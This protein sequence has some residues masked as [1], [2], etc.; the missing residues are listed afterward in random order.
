MTVAIRLMRFGKK[1]Q[2]QY[3]IVALDKRKK[4]DGSYLDKIGNYD[5]LSNPHKIDL[6]I[7]K[8][9][10]WINKGAQPSDGLRRLLKKIDSSKKASD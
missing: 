7:A 2:P 4:R 5:P 1:G 8:Y 6:N 3:R 10:S 9:E